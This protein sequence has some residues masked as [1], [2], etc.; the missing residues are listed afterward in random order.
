[1]TPHAHAT[2]AGQKFMT[3]FVFKSVNFRLFCMSNFASGA[4]I[5]SGQINHGVRNTL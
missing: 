5:L 1:M 4:T 3:F 2:D